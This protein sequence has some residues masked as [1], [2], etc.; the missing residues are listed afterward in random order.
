MT[1]GQTAFPARIPLELILGD[2]A[3]TDCPRLS[4]RQLRKSTV[5]MTVWF[6]LRRMATGGRNS[7]NDGVIF[8]IRAGTYDLA[9]KILSDTPAGDVLH[10]YRV[11][12]SL[13]A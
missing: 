7:V 4:F 1:T 6:D 3:A 2:Y 13:F 10:G 8:W 5:E 11:D 12:E 9:A